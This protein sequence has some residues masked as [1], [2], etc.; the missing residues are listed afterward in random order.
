M[1]EI[2]DV[3]DQSATPPPALLAS[4]PHRF[5]GKDLAPYS[6]GR[7]L[8]WRALF[9]SN[10]NAAD[11]L[12]SLSLIFVLSLDDPAA[13][14]YLFDIKRAKADF[15]AWLEARGPDDYKAAVVEADAILAEAKKADVRAVEDPTAQL[16]KKP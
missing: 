4:A 8:L 15:Y 5:N 9:T 12:F 2:G 3:F 7:R 6:Y 11:Q 1:T 10:D 13:C 14:D 16:K